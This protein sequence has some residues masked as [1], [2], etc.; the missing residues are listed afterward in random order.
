MKALTGADAGSGLVRTALGTLGNVNDALEANRLLR[1]KEIEAFG[2]AGY[3]GV[4]KR[5]NTPTSV[6][7]TWR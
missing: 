6:T 2:A 1:G 5:L 7:G 4:R 3:H